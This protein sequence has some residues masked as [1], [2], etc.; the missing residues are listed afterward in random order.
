MEITKT[1]APNANDSRGPG[2]ARGRWLTPRTLVIF[3]GSD[4]HKLAWIS[5]YSPHRLPPP[6]VGLVGLL[7]RLDDKHLAERRRSF[8]FPAPE[9]SPF[10]AALIAS[11]WKLAGTPALAVDRRARRQ[12]C[13]LELRTRTS[14]SISN[15]RSELQVSEERLLLGGRVTAVTVAV[16]A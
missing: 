4:S 1:Q 9:V 11:R 3:C 14:R 16:G 10:E 6:L 2:A 8:N 13:A 7:L 12:V 5:T 15:A